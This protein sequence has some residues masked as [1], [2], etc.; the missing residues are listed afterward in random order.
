MV[1]KSSMSRGP[2]PPSQ[3]I[4]MEKQKSTEHVPP[5]DVVL[6]MRP[7]ILVGPSLKGYEVTD[8][9]QKALF[10]FLKHRDGRISITRAMADISLASALS[11]NNP[12]KHVIIEHSNMRSSLAKVQSEIQRIFELARTLQLVALD[13]DTINH[14][15]QLSKTSLAPITVYIDHLPQGGHRAQPAACAKQ[16]QKSTEHVPP[17][18]VV[19]SMRPI[20]L[21]GPSLKGYEVTDMMQKA[22]FD[23]LKHRDGRIS[24][25]R[26]MADISLAKCSVLNNPSKHVI[27]EHSNMRSSLAKVQSEIQRIFELARTLQLVALDADT[28]NHPAQLSKTSLAPITVYIDHLP[29]GGHR[30]QP[31]AWC[32]GVH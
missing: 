15:A 24:I 29:Q 19:L 28:I 26:A 31:A 11:L 5:Y 25:T 6:S 8:M 9:M 1:Q 16:K 17:Y 20:I 4:P 3:E 22:L 7:I 18:D 23:F 13:A 32:R 21:V 27:I 10:D 14:P 2:Y 30:A 12:S